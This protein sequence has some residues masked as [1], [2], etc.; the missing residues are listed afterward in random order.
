ME[1][2]ISV[3]R[4]GGMARSEGML[5]GTGKEERRKERGNKGKYVRVGKIIGFLDERERKRKEKGKG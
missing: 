3:D 1:N 2:G 5:R 4:K